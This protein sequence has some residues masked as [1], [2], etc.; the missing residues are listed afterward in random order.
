MDQE[1]T[2]IFNVPSSDCMFIT[3]RRDWLKT[4]EFSKI[5]AL[6][7]CYTA[8]IS[9]NFKENIPIGVVVLLTGYKS[10]E[11]PRESDILRFP[12]ADGSP[13]TLGNDA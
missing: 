10:D 9:Q 3:I 7:D 12:N 1:S 4:F 8:K 11:Y 2:C 13:K 5:G 6:R